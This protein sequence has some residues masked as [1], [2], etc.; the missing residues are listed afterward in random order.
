MSRKT[1]IRDL[2]KKQCRALLREA[3]SF[4][5]RYRVGQF[6]DGCVGIYRRHQKWLRNSNY[7]R[8]PQSKLDWLL[9]VQADQVDHSAVNRAHKWK[10]KDIND[11][12]NA[13]AVFAKAV[14]PLITFNPGIIAHIGARVDVVSCYL[15]PRHPDSEFVSIDLQKNLKEHNATLEQSPNWRFLSGYALDLL[16]EVRPTTLM[17]MFTTCKMA[18][19]EFEAFLKLSSEIGVK[20]IVIMSTFKPKLDRFWQI[21]IDPPETINESY[22]SSGTL[23]DPKSEQNVFVHNNARYLEANGYVIK[24]SELVNIH[25]GPTDGFGHLVVASI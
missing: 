8:L 15:A 1:N 21:S 5:F 12:S 16:T 23:L 22:I 13:Y 24:R 9:Q 4:R 2:D 17:A 6:V 18:P 14:D 10:I 3:R 20:D 19:R 11:V 25:T 7:E